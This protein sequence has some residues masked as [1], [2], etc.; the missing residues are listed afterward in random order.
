[1]FRQL[2]DIHV[3]LTSRIPSATENVLH[4]IH[5]I[6]RYFDAAGIDLLLRIAGIALVAYLLLTFVFMLTQVSG[7]HMFPA[8]KDG[9]LCVVFRLQDSIG[10]GYAKGDVIA[11][12]ADG[13]RCFGRVE[14]FG[15][16]IVTMNE[17]GNFTV[18]N[19]P[20]NGEILFP[21]YARGDLE[22]PLKVPEGCLFVMGDHR[23]DTIDSRD[24]GPIP[25]E[26]VE[27]KVISILR[28]RGL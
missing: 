27:G 7:Q 20:D 24:L 12:Q 19:V 10:G 22:Y 28:R 4:A 25:L 2:H 15:G 5:Y 23:T 1:L 3:P 14:A 6:S 8:L 18:N 26:S 13:K 9:D 16:D 17:S 21:T 11:Y